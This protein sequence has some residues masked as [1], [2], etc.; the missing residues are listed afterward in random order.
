MK[1]CT[2]LSS[3]RWGGEIFRT[4]PDRPWGPPILLNNGSFPGVKRPGRDFDHPPHVAPKLK[5]E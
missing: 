3:T 1:I 2:L 4:H 5:K